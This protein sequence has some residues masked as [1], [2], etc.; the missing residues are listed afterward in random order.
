MRVLSGIQPSGKLHLGNYF[1][2]M[3]QFVDLQDENES[4]IFIANYHAMTTIKDPNFLREMTL[5]VATCYLA[6]G[7]D[8]NKVALFKQSDITRIN[9]FSWILSTLTPMGLLERCH[10]YKDKIAKGISPDH[11]LFAYPVLMAADILIYKSDIVP[12]GKDQKQHVEV[13]RDIAIKFNNTYGEILKLP[14]IKIMENT[15]VV[16]GIDGQKMSK[17][18][19]NTISPF[20]DEKEI[21]KQ[22]MRIVTDSTPVDAPKNPDKCNVFSLYKLMATEEEIELMRNK[23][24]NGGF[25]YGDAKKILFEKILDYFLEI[26]KR[27]FE[28]KRDPSYVL[29]VLKKGAEKANEIANQ[30]MEEVLK[31]VGII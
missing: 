30:T 23:Y 24:L 19:N 11:G 5:E 31:A 9:D 17:S 8:P 2:A 18:Y 20:D 14:D 1:G 3:K 25:G 6:I 10:S 7:L 12:V 13:A 26:R 27:Y 28:F 29:D 15:A 4:F 16:P 21:K 22:V